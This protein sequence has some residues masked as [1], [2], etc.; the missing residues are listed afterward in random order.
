MHVHQAIHGLSSL[1]LVGGESFFLMRLA[2]L[3]IWEPFSFRLRWKSSFLKN[4]IANSEWSGTKH[5]QVHV[6]VDG[7]HQTVCDHFRKGMKLSRLFE[8]GYP[9]PGLIKKF[10][11]R[12][13]PDNQLHM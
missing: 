12:L 4:L 2:V 7:M 11:R 8:I 3:E 5:H 9:S 1:G 10:F 13:V 6:T